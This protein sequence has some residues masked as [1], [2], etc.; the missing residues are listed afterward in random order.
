MFSLDKVTPYLFQSLIKTG[1]PQIHHTLVV[2]NRLTQD[3]S[4]KSQGKFFLSVLYTP[5]YIF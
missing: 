3:T 2:G 1:P 4:Q 5:G